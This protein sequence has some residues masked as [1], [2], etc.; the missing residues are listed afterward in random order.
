MPSYAPDNELLILA[1][2]FV[3]EVH[4]GVVSRAASALRVDYIMLRRFLVA[5]RAKPENRQVLRNALEGCGWKPA[6]DRK[7]SHEVPI[8]VTRSVLAQLIDALD[9]LQFHSPKSGR[10]GQEA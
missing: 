5:G 8:E 10:G 1:T 9:A 6:S 3:S 7:I 4:G 2:R